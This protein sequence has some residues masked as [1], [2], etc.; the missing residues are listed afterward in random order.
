MPWAGAAETPNLINTLDTNKIVNAISNNAIT[1]NT[2]LSKE[3]IAKLKK[4]L[5]NK[6]LTNVTDDNQ[7]KIGST[8]DQV[9]ALQEWLTENN[10]YA[11][12]IDG[13]YGADTE[14]AV[15]KFQA[16]IG[17]KV[18]GKVGEYTLLAMQ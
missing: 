5:E 16:Q 17:L 1:D 10:F 11:G 14:A 6:K 15:K 18:D 9:K 2:T 4:W 13:N 3:E 7:L 12:V 8:G